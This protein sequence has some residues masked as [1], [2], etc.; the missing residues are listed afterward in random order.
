MAQVGHTIKI[1]TDAYQ[2]ATK[3]VAALAQRGWGA[4]GVKR[5]GVPTLASVI[6][7]GLV[8]LET[9]LEKGPK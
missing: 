8:L 4:I 1:H 3:L 2:R 6:A 7:E 5:A 9:K